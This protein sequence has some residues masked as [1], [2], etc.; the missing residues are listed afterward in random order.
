MKVAVIGSGVSGLSAAYALH[1]DHEVV[2]YERESAVGGHVATVH[3]AADTGPVAVD[4]GFIV[5]NEKTYPRFVRLLAELG[6]ETQPSDMSLGCVST[7]SSASSPVKRG[8]VVSL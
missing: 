1:R 8:Y 7:P 5:Y 4:T 3:V 2:L 6:V